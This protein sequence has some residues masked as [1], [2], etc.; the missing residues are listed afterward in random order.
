M[1]FLG[2]VIREFLSL[3]DTPADEIFL[4][5]NHVNGR[6]RENEQAL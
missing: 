3:I 4:W 5:A 2:Y 6:L 1:P